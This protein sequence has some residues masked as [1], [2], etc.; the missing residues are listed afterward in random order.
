MKIKMTIFKIILYTVLTSILLSACA[1]HATVKPA[2]TIIPTANKGITGLRASVRVTVQQA[3]KS[4]RS[5]DAV[6]RAARPGKVRVSGLA[7]LGVT[8]FDV[9]LDGDKFWFYQPSDGYLYTGTYE[10]LRGLMKEKGID[11]DPAVIYKALFLELT[12]EG[13]GLAGPD[14]TVQSKGEIREGEFRL[15][16]ILTAHDEKAGYTIT[17]NFEKY[18]V[19]PPEGMDKEFTIEG[20][21]LKGIRTVE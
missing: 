9:V 2:A 7:L 16:L 4:D 8:V 5:F 17:V 19:N 12:G 15:P 13:D 1:P 6:L 18:I 3:G 10:S 20:G 14:I 11:I 21:E